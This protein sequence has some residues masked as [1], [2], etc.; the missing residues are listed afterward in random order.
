MES[1]T[2]SQSLNGFANQELDMLV[3]I[4]TCKKHAYLL[5]QFYATEF[6]EYLKG[7]PNT[8]VLETYADPEIPVSMHDKN[9]LTLKTNEEYE[10]LSVKTYLMIEYCIS[11]FQFKHLLKVDVTN[12][13][14][15]SNLES[16]SS[17]AEMA[18]KQLMDFVGGR[19]SFGDYEGIKLL[20]NAGRSGAENWARK[21]GGAIDY[22]RIFGDRSMSSYYTG[23]CYALS[24]RF[25]Q[26][27]AQHGAG[28]A[29]EHARYL[30]GS[31]D[32][33]IGRLI[34]KFKKDRSNEH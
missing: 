12:V 17:H 16:E 25:A 11:N 26:Y 8:L 14:P 9:Q 15:R 30:M 31:E 27:I 7:L 19:V 5:S 33:M 23:K 34:E 6:G 32:V 22:Q 3:C 29:Q 13:L 10:N 28:M 18:P 24:Y 20:S 1:S 21:K 2:R 4:Y